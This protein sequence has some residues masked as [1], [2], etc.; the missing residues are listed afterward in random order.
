MPSGHAQSATVW[1]L[2]GTY[3]RKT[4]FWILAIV[5]TAGVGISRAYLGVH[6][7]SQI[8]LGWAVGILIILCFLRFE[9]AVVSWFRNFDLVYQLLLVIACTLLIILAG[10]L[11]IK[12]LDAWKMPVAW[13]QN[14]SE[15]LILDKDGLMAYGLTS[16]MGNA[17]GFLGVCMGAIFMKRK[18]DFRVN[19]DWRIRL[20]RVMIGLVGIAS[21]FIV[22]M[23]LSPM[24]SNSIMK[25]ALRFMG[26]YLI[27]FSAIYLLPLLFLK[28]KLLK[29]MT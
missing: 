26:F 9:S 10:L 8:L 11:L 15:Y 23:V 13:T 29:V 5:L 27:S 16:I 18:G 3:L 21:I 25:A 2:A 6:F 14:A 17:G 7:L 22:V 28:M 19:G 24:M 12:F 1:L 4:W 20:L